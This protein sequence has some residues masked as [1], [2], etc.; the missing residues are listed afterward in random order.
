MVKETGDQDKSIQGLAATLREMLSTTKAI[1]NL[2]LIPNT[3]NVIEEIIRQSLETAVLIG[4]YTNLD[5]GS[6]LVPHLHDPA[7]PKDAFL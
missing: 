5:F 3:T 7:E 6:N 2:E 4:V 1:P